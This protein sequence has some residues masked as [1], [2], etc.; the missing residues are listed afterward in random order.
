MS[1]RACQSKKKIPRFLQ[2][3]LWSI[4]VDHLDLKKDKVYIINQV[5]VYGGFKELRWLFRIYP[6]RAIKE[7]FIHRPL[8]I[9]SPSAFNFAKEILLGLKNRNLKLANYDR[10]SPRIIR[11]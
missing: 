6:K 4:K 2:P 11:S 5:L 1:K 3:I 9:Y 7:I 10:N 8:K